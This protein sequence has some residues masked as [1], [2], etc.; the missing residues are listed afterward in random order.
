MFRS[1]LLLHLLA[2]VFMMG[3]IWFV[4]IVHYP[5]FDGVTAEAFT[6]Y[7]L[8]HTDATGWVV[9]PAMLVE[10]V[11]AVWLVVL[12]HRNLRSDE[13]G[14][15]MIPRGAA[16]LGL[17][18]VVLLAMITFLLSWPE[19]QALSRGFDAEAHRR[20]VDTN[21]LRTLLWTTRSGLA[22]WMVGRLLP[23][24]SMKGRLP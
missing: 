15:R 18:M 6:T 13:V 9:G 20:L 16:W 12:S 10:V 14:R 3:V 7:E 21:W 22:L 24:G 8:R 11:T 23:A 2:T 4:Q 17:G 1:I 19:H 5:L